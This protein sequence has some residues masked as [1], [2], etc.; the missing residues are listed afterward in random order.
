MNPTSP[1][2][3]RADYDRSV[4][5]NCP[6]DKDYRRFFRA[7][8]FSVQDCGFAV[9]Y[10]LEISDASETRAVKLIR[11][12]KS[13][14]LG[15]HDISRTE[16]DG[17]T[18][19]PRFN[20]PYE[21]GLFVGCKFAGRRKQLQK[22]ALILD[23]EPYRFQKFLSDIAGQDIVSHGGRLEDLM[24]SVRNWLTH[25]TQRSLPGA[26][27]LLSRFRTFESQIPDILRELNRTES[28][29]D[30]YIDLYKI[31]ATWIEHNA[32]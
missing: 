11:L 19:L 24:T 13:A 7:L 5:V 27:H 8:I 18:Q 30:N 21:L 20:M 22:S 32:E 14:K 10:A 23:C 16:L 1:D 9:R 26:K 25:Y 29:L 17:R 12:I 15:I 3:R 2:V 6:F 28:D 31:S 4:F